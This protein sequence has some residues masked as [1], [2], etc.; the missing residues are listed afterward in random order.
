MGF[1]CRLP[2]V[3]LIRGLWIWPSV[4]SLGTSDGLGDVCSDGG[5]EDGMKSGS[6]LSIRLQLEDGDSSCPLVDGSPD[7][8]RT[9]NKVC[10]RDDLGRFSDFSSCTIEWIC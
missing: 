6:G 8:L 4:G 5:T 3:N 2:P 1:V 9:G 7:G 10:P